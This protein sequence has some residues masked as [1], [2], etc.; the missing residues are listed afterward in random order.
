MTDPKYAG[1]VIIIAGYLDLMEKLLLSNP[2]T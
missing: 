2:G 1:T